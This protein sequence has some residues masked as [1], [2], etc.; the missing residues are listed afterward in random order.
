M[1]IRTSELAVKGILQRDYDSRRKPAILPYIE[2]ASAM[3]DDVVACMVAAEITAHPAERLE[4][5]ERW[6]AA[7]F[8][9]MS[10]QQFAS[11]A[12][13]GASASYRPQGGL[14]LDGSTYGQHAKR[15]DSS[16]CLASV[17]ADPA[18]GGDPEVGGFWAGTKKSDQLS[19]E[20]R[21]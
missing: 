3:V 10:D 11:S 21:N 19:Y 13:D 8:Y 18:A 9:K 20:D 7:H 1:T 2:S 4:L 6:L 5:I 14:G 16:G 15:L 12:A 17:D